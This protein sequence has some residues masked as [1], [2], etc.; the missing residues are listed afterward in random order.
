MLPAGT[1]ACL[2]DTQRSASA[3]RCRP[4]QWNVDD[5]AQSDVQ[6]SRAAR[7]ILSGATAEQVFVVNL[8]HGARKVDFRKS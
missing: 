1:I 2:I 5:L 6:F 3:D 7:E 8:M 4:S